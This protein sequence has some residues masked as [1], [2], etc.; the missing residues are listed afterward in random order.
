MTAGP[1]TA[2]DALL[3]AQLADP[4]CA[5]S[6]GSYGAGAVFARDSDEPARLLA[7]GRIGLLT[8][9]GGLAFT[10]PPD[11]RPVAYETGFTDGWSQSVALCLPEAACAMGRRTVL[12]ELGP[13]AAAIRPQD[14]VAA[15]FDLGL[16]LRAVDA[17][18]RVADP[19][20]IGRLRALAGRPLLASGD[21][22]ILRAVASRLDR[23]FL[24]RFARIEVFA[25]ETDPAA[26]GIGPQ[27]HI[28]PSWLR[29]GRTHAAT[30]PIPQ[31]WVP[32]GALHPAH[33]ARDGSG[34]PIPFD[35]G[36]HGAFGRVLDAWGDPALVAL[37]RAILAGQDPDTVRADGRF[38]R[39][40]IRAARVQRR[41]MV[42]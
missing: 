33:P 42:G 41:A 37:R 11:L 30:A 8:A 23:I 14:R 27:S 17:C 19:E 31:G 5:W 34:R 32:C 9:R 35:A 18:L 10:V 4:A 3:R 12:T 28:L 22:E 21:T 6:L 38:A 15:L 2:V 25:A 36:R 39:L 20:R 1:G 16:G 7:D 13:D 40:A 24:T 29:L 26:A